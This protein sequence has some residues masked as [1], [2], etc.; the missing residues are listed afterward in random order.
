MFYYQKSVWF[1]NESVKFT[2]QF[3]YTCVMKVLKHNWIDITLYMKV[4][5]IIKV[6]L[7]MIIFKNKENNLTFPNNK[8]IKK[9][10]QPILLYTD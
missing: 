4:Q 9:L 2:I 10:R 5:E 1:F 8:I 6:S 3:I 7:N